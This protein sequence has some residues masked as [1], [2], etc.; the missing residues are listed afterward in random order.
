MS[1]I[2]VI[3]H[4][5]IGPLWLDYGS[6]DASGEGIGGKLAPTD[7]LARIE[8]DFWYNEDSEKS[9]KNGEMKNCY[10]FLKLEAEYLQLTG[11]KL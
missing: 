11:N 6:D 4:L 9:A 8:I 2:M 7:L 5:V 3:I 10:K 1:T